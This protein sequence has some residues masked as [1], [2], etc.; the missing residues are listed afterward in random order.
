MNFKPVIQAI[1]EGSL[2]GADGASSGNSDVINVEGDKAFVIRVDGYTPEKPQSFDQ[3]SSEIREL[4]KRQKAENAARTQGE[5]NLGGI[6]A[7]KRHSNNEKKKVSISARKKP[8]LALL[9]MKC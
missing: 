4:I 8:C 7:G 3:A 2:I 9:M 6:A 5:K 1:F